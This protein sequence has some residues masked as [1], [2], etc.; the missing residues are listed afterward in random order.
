MAD[1]GRSLRQSQEPFLI[2]V[3][4]GTGSGRK[5]VCDEIIRLLEKKGVEARNVCILHQ[6]SFYKELNAEE[7]QQAS[8]GNYNFDHPDTFDEELMIKTL[9]TISAGQQRVQVPIYDDTANAKTTNLQTIF[10][11]RVVLFEGILV[12]YSSE[13]RNMLDMKLFVDV[14]S[15]TRLARRVLRDVQTR[16]RNL[17]QVLDQYIELV[18]PA[19]E[20]FTLPTKKHADVIIPRGR[21]NTIAID[22]IADHIRDIVQTGERKRRVSIS[23]ARSRTPSTSDPGEPTRPH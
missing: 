1:K 23:V 17:E 3:T 22:L 16:G 19:F 9:Q 20:D 13:V 15:D 11:V 12:L 7:T 5:S 8:E 4:G 6:D 2:G 14:D 21:D 18:K 10:D